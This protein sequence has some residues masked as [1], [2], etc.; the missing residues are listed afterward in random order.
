[1]LKRFKQHFQTSSLEDG[2]DEIK[3][4]HMNLTQQ[5]YTVEEINPTCYRP[6]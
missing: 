6:K 2:V 3:E 1:M 4:L 5:L